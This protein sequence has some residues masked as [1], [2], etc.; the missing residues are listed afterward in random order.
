MCLTFSQGN[1]TIWHSDADDSQDLGNWIVTQPW[2]NGDVYTFG[3][4][5]DGL[6]A[7]R[8]PDNQPEWY[9]LVLN[10]IFRV[11][12]KAFPFM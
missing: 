10:I 6:A 11:N 1:F 5:A 12:I 3:A 7:F 9:V 2:S 4:S 8:T